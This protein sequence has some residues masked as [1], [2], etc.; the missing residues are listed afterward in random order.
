MNSAAGHGKPVDI[1]AMGVITYFLLCGYTPFDRDSQEQE[2]EA[3][4]AGDYAFEPE[5]YWMNV[6]ETARDFVRMCLTADPNKRPTAKQALEHKWL[7]SETPHFVADP[8]SPT[9]GPKDL[10]PTI[11]KGF[12]AK[13][14]CELLPL[15]V[16][17]LFILKC[18]L[19][20][21]KRFWV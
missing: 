2:M 16:D 19:Q 13:K 5:E 6:S 14:T 4:L 11:R 8:E 18:L 21:A 12:N 1:W 9:G 17:S 15:N 7:A 10:L 20:S 3:I